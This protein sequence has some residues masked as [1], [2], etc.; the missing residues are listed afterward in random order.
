MVLERLDI[1]LMKNKTISLLFTTCK[2]SI[3]NASKISN[4][5]LKLKPLH[6]NIVE[7][8]QDIEKG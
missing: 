1:L 4:L 3:Q 6:E 8:L 7:K 5:Y 2:K